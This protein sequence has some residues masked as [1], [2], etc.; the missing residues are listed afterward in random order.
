MDLLGGY[1]SDEDGPAPAKATPAPSQATSNG[2]VAAAKAAPEPEPVAEDEPEPHDSFCECEDCSQLLLRFMGKNLQTKGIR[3]K[4]KLSGELFSTK[5]EASEHF[6]DAYADELQKFKKAKMPKLF[7]RGTSKEDLAALA[8]KQLFSRDAVLAKKRPIDEDA[9]FGGWAK[10]E[11]PAP[12]PCETEEYQQQMESEV[13]TAPPW[14]G[15]QRPT[16]EDATDMDKGVD[17]QIVQAQT[18]RFCKRNILEV[19]KEVV[20]CKLCYKTLSSTKECE[21]HIRKDHEDDFKKE[22]RIWER[23]LFSTCKRQPPF[24]WVCKICQIFFPS[25]GACWRHVGKECYIRLE[26]RHMG[27]WHEKEDRWGHEEDEECCGDGM[28]VGKGLSWESVMQFNEAEAKQKEAEA[29]AAAAKAAPRPE[30]EESSS[31]SEDEAKVG[32]V[33]AIREF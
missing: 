7:Q 10:K 4:C 14:L 32:K 20:R 22:I 27:A 25:D 19:K 29:R 13:F 16:D 18:T 24:G 15:A 17:R 21:D 23:F 26:E 31:S 1:D 12:A 8:R 3:F 2:K 33:Q 11:K 9:S 5:A 28:N 30:E 6:R